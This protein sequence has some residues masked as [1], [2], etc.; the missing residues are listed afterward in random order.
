MKK[1]LGE[2]LVSIHFDGWHTCIYT[3]GELFISCDFIYFLGNTINGGMKCP[4]GLIQLTTVTRDPRSADSTEENGRLPFN[5]K[6][7]VCLCCT[8][9]M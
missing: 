4:L 5:P 2:I 3:G 1:P 9:V 7:F 6:I 8:I